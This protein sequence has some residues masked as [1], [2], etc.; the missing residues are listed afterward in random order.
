MSEHFLRGNFQRTRNY[1]DQ[2]SR[3][4]A[5]ARLAL[6]L[7]GQFIPFAATLGHTAGRASTFVGLQRWTVLHQADAM[8][9][10]GKL[11][12][13]AR[14]ALRKYH[15]ALLKEQARYNDFLN[16][17]DDELSRRD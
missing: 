7:V 4:P 6:G 14:K 3:I 17:I 12:I 11:P 2:V 10:R 5:S 13:G 16:A 1:L 9:R 15:A 8:D